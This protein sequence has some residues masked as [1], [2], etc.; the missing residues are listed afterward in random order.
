MYNL[1]KHLTFKAFWTST[2]S[3]GGTDS[4]FSAL[5]PERLS[6]DY[7]KKKIKF[8]CSLDNDAIYEACQRNSDVSRPTYT[9]LNRMIAQVVSSIAASLRSGDSLNTDMNKIDPD[10]LGPL[11]PCPIPPMVNYG[12]IFAT[13]KSY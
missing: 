2:L 4:G 11:S 9:H 3:A 13:K 10:Q 7:G 6:A 5:L 12:P 1:L 8:E